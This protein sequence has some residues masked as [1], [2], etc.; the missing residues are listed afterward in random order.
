MRNDRINMERRMLF[1]LIG[2]AIGAATG[3]FTWSEASC[4]SGGCVFNAHPLGS[5]LRGAL[6][7]G[8][9]GNLVGDL[10]EN[11][12]MRDRRKAATKRAGEN[13]PVQ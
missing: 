9:V 2:A 6:L 3:W 13:G 12:R 5:A 11:S 4:T 8:L 10:V 1:L 7:G